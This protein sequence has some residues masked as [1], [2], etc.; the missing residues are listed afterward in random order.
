MKP[1]ETMRLAQLAEKEAALRRMGFHAIAGLDEAGRGPLAGPVV[2]AAV[3]LPSGLLLQGLNDSKKVSLANRYRLE[4]EIKEKAVAWGIGEASPQEIDGINILNATKM[5]MGRALEAMQV[6]PDYLLI[7]A[8]RL[9][10]SLPQEAIIRGDAQIA[11]ISAASI[12]AKTH[13]DRLMEEWD[14]TY[15]AYGFRQNKGY[16]TAAHRKTVI[17]IGP[18][19]IHRFTF[20]GFAAK[21]SHVQLAFDL[22]TE[23]DEV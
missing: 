13:R 15:P 3:I 8:L 7:D 22:T 19:P 4:A 23:A 6:Q 12:L 17:E 18:C 16:P 5:A 20:L 21:A 10:V 14:A 2:A 9:V 11:C 1:N